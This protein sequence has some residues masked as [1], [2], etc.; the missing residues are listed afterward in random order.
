MHTMSQKSIE[1]QAKDL[2]HQGNIACPK[3][4]IGHRPLE[5]AP[6]GLSG[7]GAHGPCTVCPYCG[8]EYRCVRAKKWPLGIDRPERAPD[9]SLQA[10]LVPRA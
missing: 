7:G 5:R 10:P 4:A 6:Q 2:D 3:P 8:T 9:S 1:L